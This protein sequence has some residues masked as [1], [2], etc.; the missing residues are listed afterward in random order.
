MLLLLPLQPPL[1]DNCP[2]QTQQPCC[3]QHRAST[4]RSCMAVAA[5]AV[6]T[7]YPA[8]DLLP[9]AA[10]VHSRPCR[11]QPQQQPIKVQQYS[12]Q[13][14][15]L[16]PAADS[17]PPQRP[18]LPHYHCCRCRRCCCMPCSSTSSCRICPR[19]CCCRCCCC[20]AASSCCCITP[21]GHAL[22]CRIWNSAIKHT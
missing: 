17:W 10:A 2:G 1:L 19:M 14:Q 9:L 6:S 4:V 20:A 15:V 13:L 11:L 8:A 22:C 16:L 12:F 7:C 5:Q 3:C 21:A 18:P